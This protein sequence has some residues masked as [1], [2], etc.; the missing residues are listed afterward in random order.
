MKSKHSIT[1][2]Q[3]I[4]IFMMS[5]GLLNHVT[6]IPVLLE[7]T[8]RDAWI[9]VVI[10]TLISLVWNLLVAF[11]I[12]RM[13][14]QPFVSWL[15]RKAGRVVAYGFVGLLAVQLFMMAGVTLLDMVF[16]TKI[17]YLTKTPVLVLVGSFLFLCLVNAKH[18]LYSVRMTT[19]ILILFVVTFGF[20]VATANMNRKDFS[21]LTPVLQHGWHPVGQGV[22]Y[23]ATGFLEPFWVLLLQ[24]RLRKRGSVWKG[25]TW[26]SVSLLFLTIGPLTGA[27][28]EFGTMGSAQLRYPAFE[29]W[30]LVKIGDYIE[31]VDFLSIF[32]WMTGS[33]I[34]ISFHL[35]LLLELL[36]LYEPGKEKRKKWVLVGLF[37]GLTLLFF[38]PVNAI[39]LFDLLRDYLMPGAVGGLLL[40]S[41]A[42]CIIAAIGAREER[43][44]EDEGNETPRAV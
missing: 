17:S 40:F 37:G 6:L 29:E 9:S 44:N 27:I 38:L 19:S 13:D 25:L 23:A 14:R 32:Q 10:V 28:M 35:Y 7:T 4:L 16:W 42:L 39:S 12:R 5:T 3:L 15:K 34:R 22:I 2:F 21:L 41:L 8:G 18:G 1:F 11:I 43:A 33:F 20:F 24:H 26:I 30:R 31:H 36:G